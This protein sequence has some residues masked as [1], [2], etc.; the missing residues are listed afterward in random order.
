MLIHNFNHYNLKK[1][2]LSPLFSKL[3][4]IIFGL[5]QSILCTLLLP[6]N[7]NNNDINNNKM[8]ASALANFDE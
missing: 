7:N 4:Y 5:R 2:Y 6:N 8:E 1:M 3:G